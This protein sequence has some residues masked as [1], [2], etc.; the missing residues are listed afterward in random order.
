LSVVV[1]STAQIVPV[2]Q[3]STITTID[4]EQNFRDMTPLFLPLMV[5]DRYRFKPDYTLRTEATGQ[6]RR[7]VSNDCAEQMGLPVFLSVPGLLCFL[8]CF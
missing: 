3:K 5:S 6:I 8:E 2:A 1:V 7:Q 4:N